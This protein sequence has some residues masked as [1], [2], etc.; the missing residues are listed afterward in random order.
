MSD[1]KT[2]LK[3][4]R[5]ELGA[6]LEKLEHFLTTDNLDGIEKVQQELLKLQA[7]AMNT[8]LCVLNSRIELM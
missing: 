8:Y 4:E 2:R 3:A 6:K 5:E 1:F 7:K